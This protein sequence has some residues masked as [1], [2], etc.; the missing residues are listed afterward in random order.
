MVLFSSVD[1]EIAASRQAGWPPVKQW[2]LES[3]HSTAV[4]CLIQ[5]KQTDLDHPDKKFGVTSRRLP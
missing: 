2:N 4:E 5:I 1:V 3:M